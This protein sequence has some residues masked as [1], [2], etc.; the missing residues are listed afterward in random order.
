MKLVVLSPETNRVREVEIV[1]RMFDTGLE[2]FHVR[3][4]DFKNS[5]YREYIQSFDVRYHSKL[6]LH[7]GGFELWSE[8]DL[9]GVHLNASQRDSPPRLASE[10]EVSKLSSSFHR[11]SEITNSRLD[12]GYLFISPVF[13]SISKI[14]YKAGVDFRGLDKVKNHL[15]SVN[16]PI[17]EIFGLGGIDLPHF[18][19]LQDHKFDGAAVFGAIW[20]APDPVEYLSRILKLI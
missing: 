4:P 11:W 17:P 6:V 8:F 19:V 7:G 14:K 10:L 13:D 3:K 12:F 5:D 2:R 9:G 16:R 20:R 1:S 18:K 15:T